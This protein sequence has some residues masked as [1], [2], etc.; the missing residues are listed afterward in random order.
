MKGVSP[1]LIVVLIFVALLI[2]FA[3]SNL[4]VP[5]ERINSTATIVGSMW[6]HN[7]TGVAIDIVTIMVYVNIT[8]FTATYNLYS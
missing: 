1:L 7:D 3:I 8:N 5:V 2:A 4:R 6:Q